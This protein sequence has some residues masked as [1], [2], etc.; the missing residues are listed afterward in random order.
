MNKK[1]S[2]RI[3]DKMYTDEDAFI[4]DLEQVQGNYSVEYSYEEVSESQ[5][6]QQTKP[7]SNSESGLRK[8]FKDFSEREVGLESFNQLKQD[9]IKHFEKIDDSSLEKDLNILIGEAQELF[10]D[11][12]A[13]EQSIEHN[14]KLLAETQKQLAVYEEQLSVAQRNVEDYTKKADSLKKSC[15]KERE[16]LKSWKDLYNFMIDISDEITQ[17]ID[18][19]LLKKQCKCDC[20]CECDNKHKDCTCKKQPVKPSWMPDNHFNLLKEIFG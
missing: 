4:K 9:I 1:F 13:I 20:G 10:T 16:G 7:E 19:N 17:W 12:F 3:N 15:E 8:I 11:L 2:G 5:E 14:E 6:P 18:E